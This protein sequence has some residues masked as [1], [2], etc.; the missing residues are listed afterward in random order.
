MNLINLDFSAPDFS[1]YKYM[2]IYIYIYVCV[3]LYLFYILNIDLLYCNI[4]LFILLLKPLQIFF[5]EYLK[6]IH[7]IYT[8][9]LYQILS[10]L[11]R[12][13]T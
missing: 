13:S 12:F 2:C 9:Y 10:M 11:H 7:N 3:Y 6:R 5:I 4:N 1:S 8:T